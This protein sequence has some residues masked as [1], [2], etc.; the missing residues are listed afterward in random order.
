MS[1][2]RA[3]DVADNT[4]SVAEVDLADT[5]AVVLLPTIAAA[6]NL[7]L[8]LDTRDTAESDTSNGGA[9]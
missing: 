5:A 7:A 8:A 4:T 6:G 9:A 2:W 1:D 3:L